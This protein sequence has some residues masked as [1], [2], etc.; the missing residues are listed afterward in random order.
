M[1]PGVSV[2]LCCYNSAHRLPRALAHLAVQRVP[3]TLDWEVIIVDNASDD[4]TR[5]VALEAW[6]RVGAVPLRV[7]MESRSGQAFAR[8]RGLAEAKYDIVS[9]VDDDNWVCPEWVELVWDVMKSHPDVGACG[10][11]SEA[12]CEVQPPKWFEDYKASYAIG[13]ESIKSGD[14]TNSRGWL[15][16][17]GLSI[18]KSAWQHLV[19]NGFFPLLVGR[20]PG[21]L[22]SGDDTELCFALR[23]AGWRLWYEPRLRLQ[24]FLSAPRLKWTYL[25]KLHRAFGASTV[26]HDPYLFALRGLQALPKRRP[27]WA[28]ELIPVMK[29]IYWSKRS[30]LS[31]IGFF[32]QGN[33]E[34]LEIDKDI[35]RLFELL[36]RRMRYDL[37]IREI[38]GAGWRRI[39]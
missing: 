33:A 34:I 23:L 30:L 29:R 20:Q 5:D 27:L 8:N 28:E 10:G 6:N 9:F 7:V 38:Q 16:G 15:W 4:K 26:G 14:I 31:W 12:L 2:V 11:F 36:H 13:P 32:S 21:K 3:K 18:R 37:S 24:H 25:R 35:G 1:A 39:G 22:G 17:A 19:S